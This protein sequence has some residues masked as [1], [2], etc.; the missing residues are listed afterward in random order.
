MTTLERLADR[1][2]QRDLP[3][4]P[5]SFPLARDIVIVPPGEMDKI[6][7]AD[8][9][10]REVD[11]AVDIKRLDFLGP[12]TGI[13]HEHDSRPGPMIKTKGIDPA[14]LLVGDRPMTTD[15]TPMRL[16]GPLPDRI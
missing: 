12:E 4:R 5:G 3:D 6:T 8:H 16:R 10:G 2:Q 7:E 15:G 9:T 1:I 14:P 13:E 11:G